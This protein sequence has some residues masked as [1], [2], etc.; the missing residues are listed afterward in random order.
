MSLKVKVSDE[1]NWLME[2]IDVLCKTYEYE[3]KFKKKDFHLM[4]ELPSQKIEEVDKQYADVLRF[5]REVLYETNKFYEEGSPLSI[6]LKKE[7]GKKM[8]YVGYIS[9][10]I[11]RSRMEDFSFHDFL[12]M[13]F[14]VFFSD[15]FEKGEID[16]KLKFEKGVAL[17][18]KSVFSSE[19]IHYEMTDMLELIMKLSYSDR[20][21]LSLLKLYAEPMPY[22]EEF[23]DRVSSCIE[24]LKKHYSL[25]EERVKKK[26][27]FYRSA[28]GKKV[29]GE[30]FN[31]V[32]F[33]KGIMKENLKKVFPLQVVGF[34]CNS[35]GLTNW[36]FEEEVEKMNFFM[37]LI[38]DEV[39]E[40]KKRYGEGEEKLTEQAKAVGDKTRLIILRL[41][42]ERPYFVKELAGKLSM[43]SA[44]LSHHL[45]LLSNAGLLTFFF[46]DRKMY[47]DVNRENLKKLGEYLTHLAEEK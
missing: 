34:Q 21:K 44:S 16:E 18:G 7:E 27:T 23:K 17:Y 25:I 13:N 3:G 14:S 29:L 9:R 20:L 28:E 45:S 2:G 42:S 12:L 6:F 1:I 36:V 15:L 41:L 19:K 46:E 43:S 11:D 37:G 31:M 40:I 39:L 35:G 22:Y 5:K 10:S 24:I 32:D 26:R 47:Y 8:S 38:V 4:E 30:L 33:E